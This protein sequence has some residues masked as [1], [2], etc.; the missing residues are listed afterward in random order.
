MKCLLNATRWLCGRIVLCL[1]LGALALP[2]TAAAQGVT[3]GS[4]TGIVKDAQEKPVAGAT[5]LALHVPSGT[6]Y[7]ATTRADGRY[8]I[9]GMRV[10]GP[11]SVTVAPSGGAAAFEAQTQEDIAINLGVGTDLDFIVRSIAVEVTVT[12]PSSYAVFSS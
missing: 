3:T 6:T 2:T 7:E 5:V 11:Y 8:T 10:G 4:L 1:M 9:P 12:A